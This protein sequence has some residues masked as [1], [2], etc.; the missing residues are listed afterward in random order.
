MSHEISKKKGQNLSNS[1]SITTWIKIHGAYNG[2][3]KPKKMQ[4]ISS[5][6]NVFTSSQP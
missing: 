1:L 6:I 2:K 5:S 4:N 3:P